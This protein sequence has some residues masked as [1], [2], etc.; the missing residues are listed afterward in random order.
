[1]T[2]LQPSSLQPQSLQNKLENLMSTPQQP[3]SPPNV[4]TAPNSSSKRKS[5]NYFL[6][7]IVGS[8]IGFIAYRLS[9]DFGWIQSLWLQKNNKRINDPRSDKA[10]KSSSSKAVRVEEPVEEDDEEDAVEASATLDELTEEELADS[11][12]QPL[13]N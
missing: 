5:W 6:V 11:N 12:F 7:L 13:S 10:S 3:T 4:D 8:V 2:S 1:M 9:Q